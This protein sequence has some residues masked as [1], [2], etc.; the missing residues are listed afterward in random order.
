MTVEASRW[1]Y[2]ELAAKFPELEIYTGG[3][4]AA[5]E[6]GQY[7]LGERVMEHET[8]WLFTWIYSER[9]DRIWAA[10]GGMFGM[11]IERIRRDRPEEERIL[12]VL[13][14]ED[15]DAVSFEEIPPEWRPDAAGWDEGRL[16]RP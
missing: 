7:E 8:Y 3:W 11:V 2:Q 13:A 5:E 10:V 4:G 1:W 16:P 9:K 15:P 14:S 12:R 6:L